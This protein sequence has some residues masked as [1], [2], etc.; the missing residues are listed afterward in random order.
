MTPGPPEL[1]SERGLDTLNEVVALPRD[2]Y[3]AEARMLTETE[4]GGAGKPPFYYDLTSV[5][6]DLSYSVQRGQ[7]AD[8]AFE[9]EKGEGGSFALL[10]SAAQIAVERRERSAARAD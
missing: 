6:V 3:N 1:R 9:F 5:K 7:A 8:A 2:H 10:E 4:F